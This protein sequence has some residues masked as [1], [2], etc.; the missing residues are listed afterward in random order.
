MADLTN[1]YV[2]DTYVGLIK[3]K[4]EEVPLQSTLQPLTDGYNNELPIQVSTTGAT[5]TGATITGTLVGSASYA[6]NAGSSISAS[7]AANAT[8]SSYALNSTTSSFSLE[9]VS[10]SYAL[11]STSASYALNATSSSYASNSTSSSYSLTST[12]SSFALNAESSSYAFNA[13]TASYVPGI[14]AP[15]DGEVAISGSGGL[16][17]NGSFTV[18]QSTGTTITLTHAD[19]SSQPS[20]DGSGN[21]VI[22]DVS[23]DEYGH[24]IGLG[25]TTITSVNTAT[26]ASYAANATSSSY[27]LMATT[28]QNAINATS[29]SYADVSVSSSYSTTSTSASYSLNSTS[30]SYAVNAT[31]SSYALVSTNANT[32]SYVDYPNIDNLPDFQTLYVNTSGDTMS[33]D[34]IVSGNIDL[35]GSIS[36]SKIELE[37]LGGAAYTTVQ[38]M[39][40]V[41]HSSGLVTGGTISDN[42][43][44]SIA[45]SAGEGYIR[46]ADSEVATLIA[47]HWDANPTVSLTDNNLNY[48]YVFY[49][50]GTPSIV[51]ST[52]E[53]NSN[54]YFLLGTVYREGIVLHETVT[55]VF[56]VGDHAAN[57][58]KRLQATAPFAREEG[59]VLTE[60]GT[61]NIAVSS[62]TW[63]EGLKQYITPAFDSSGSDT[64][65]CYYRDGG[66]GFTVITG[67]TQI[68]NTQYDNGTGSL[69]NLTVNRFGV[70]WIYLDPE[71]EIYCVFGR[72]NYLITEAEAATSPSTLP[73]F[74]TGHARLI[75][76][77]IIQQGASSFT[78][79][80]SAFET[81]L[82][83][84]SGIQNVADD[85]TPQLGG[86]LD[87][88]TYDIYTSTTNGDINLIPSG[89][90]TVNITGSLEVTGAI[91]GSLFGTASYA[92]QALSSSYAVNA[93]TGSYVE[94]AQ[95]ASY[96]AY[97]NVDGA[98]TMGQLTFWSGSQASYD[99]LG[100]WDG[101]TLYFITV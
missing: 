32:A 73:A 85:V 51:S 50:S 53:Q 47:I 86:D 30:A 48:I 13:T 74:F 7:Y 100:S 65:N 38:Q 78:D 43:D 24:V 31:S 45:V 49:N 96:V 63:W 62:G 36:G 91:T 16:S 26:S 20:I 39:Q 6:S 59:G 25:T 2:Q 61:R 92:S 75:G 84:S 94:T 57:M 23:L 28:A 19:T 67:Q 60:V 80:T 89:S 79:I 41:Y 11:N 5:I 69:A 8:S 90:G 72:G 44:G 76:K 12:T 42:G 17:G 54:N 82:N 3:L 87:V 34:L 64:F 37:N 81:N 97:G 55:K 14:S 27:A 56:N 29:S 46:N 66:S 71:G 9:S 35:T 70:H 98:G 77:I 18:N 58:I 10:S 22:Q 52:S 88:L 68:N 40:D 1:K 4:N 95:T 99:G 21:T 33:G 93:D 83:F 101:D 15:G